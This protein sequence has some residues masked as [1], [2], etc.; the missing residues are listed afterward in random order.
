MAPS[1]CCRLH[2]YS[3][4][5]AAAQHRSYR[6]RIKRLEE[7]LF[8][9]PIR[10]QLARRFGVFPVGDENASRNGIITYHSVESAQHEIDVF[11]GFIPLHRNRSE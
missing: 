6:R 8:L 11:C 5:P 7:G 1:R 10:A 9:H 2:P 4:C 3:R